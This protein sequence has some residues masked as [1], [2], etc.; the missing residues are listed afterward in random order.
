M[1]SS[2]LGRALTLGALLL[3]TACAPSL[4]RPLDAAQ[5]ESLRSTDV[6]VRI[7]QKEIDAQIVV[8]NSSAA[9]AQYGLLGALI[10]SAVDAGVNA[11]R[12]SDAEAAV[13]PLRDALLGFDFDAAFRQDLERQLASV[14]WL[15]A[16]GTTVSKQGDVDHQRAVIVSSKAVNVLLV[17][18][19]YEMT[20]DFS[21][22]RVGAYVSLMPS[23]P[24]PD[25]ESRSQRQQ[26]LLDATNPAKALYFDTI[27]VEAAL[28]A[29]GTPEANRARWAADGGEALKRALPFEAA[30]LARLV[31]VDLQSAAPAAP[32][33]AEQTLEADEARKVVRAVD[34]TLKSTVSLAH[35]LAQAPA[36]AAGAATAAA[37]DAAA[38]PA[39]A[40][41]SD[42]SGGAP[43]PVAAPAAPAQ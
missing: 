13:R 3:A 34:G 31:A 2:V 1:F 41:S 29:K 6:V 42:A 27:T 35:L 14:P 40:P 20:P 30:E 39:A 9:T 43:V 12:A 25:G 11:S 17:D 16:Q 5:R 21:A 18:T 38:A 7:P 4:H 10:S 32:Q 37:A 26:R 24:A 8:A 19:A 15:A 22:L 28:E 36:P 33:Q 23:A